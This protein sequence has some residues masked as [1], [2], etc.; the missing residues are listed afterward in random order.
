MH[1]KLESVGVAQFAVAMAETVPRLNE[2]EIFPCPDVA[3]SLQKPLQTVPHLNTLSKQ[4]VISSVVFSL[5]TVPHLNTLA[6]FVT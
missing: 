5:Q 2:G 3:R 4:K 1:N 6:I